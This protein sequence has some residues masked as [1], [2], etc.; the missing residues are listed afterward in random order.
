MSV[1]VITPV[2]RT[3]GVGLTG[4]TGESGAAALGGYG[5]AA[6]IPGFSASGMAADRS[7][8]FGAATPAQ[9]GAGRRGGAA[10]EAAGDLGQAPAVGVA[11]GAHHRRSGGSGR[12]AVG[13]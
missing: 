12:Q 1:M 10:S 3:A 8:P 4:E 9:D 2:S 13:G 11:Q 7:T 5:C 6:A